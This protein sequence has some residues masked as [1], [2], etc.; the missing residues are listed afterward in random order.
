MK[1]CI[2]PGHCADGQRFCG[3]TSSYG[4][5][6]TQAR[7]VAKEVE[8]KLLLAGDE[9]FYDAVDVSSSQLDNLKTIVSR[10]NASGADR[11]VSIH[12]NAYNGSAYGTEVFCYSKNDSF[13]KNQGN[14][15]LNNICDLG[16]RKRG[17]KDNSQE[18][19][20]V[21][22][23]TSMQAIL[24]ECC[25]IDNKDDMNRYD[26]TKMA[27]AIVKGLIGYVPADPNTGGGSNDGKTKY[28]RVFAE[29]ND[30]QEASEATARK[31]QQQ[32]KEFS[33]A[34]VSSTVV[35]GKKWYRV[36]AGSYTDPKGAEMAI[37]K[38]KALNYKSPWTEIFYK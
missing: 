12:F 18:S 10:A 4:K 34:W 32:D 36:I 13:A 35:N 21:I 3:T 16:F 25:F 23:N 11:F 33:G 37:S 2:N 30:T 26:A 9:V 5:E 24:I 19:L 17:L 29:S 15:V 22:R 38:L 20:Y 14:A 28:T 1:W 7:I 8:R 27:H 31:L 6:S